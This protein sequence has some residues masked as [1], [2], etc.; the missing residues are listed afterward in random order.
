[1]LRELHEISW[2]SLNAFCHSSHHS[3]S[4]EFHLPHTWLGKLSQ[5]SALKI[6]SEN[7][8]ETSRLSVLPALLC[9]WNTNFP[10]IPNALDIVC[11]KHGPYAVIELHCLNNKLWINWRLVSKSNQ[12][13]PY[14]CHAVTCVRERCPAPFTLATCSRQE[15]WPQH[16]ESDRTG[17]APH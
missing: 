9:I 14:M 3:C 2:Y 7:P 4:L 13:S 15:S 16:L 1:M 6:L 12:L 5:A 10:D 17:R 8:S 11:A